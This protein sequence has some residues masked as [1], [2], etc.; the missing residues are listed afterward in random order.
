MNFGINWSKKVLKWVYGESSA[1]PWFFRP[2]EI[3]HGGMNHVTVEI[4]TR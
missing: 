2:A 3:L 1:G 4:M